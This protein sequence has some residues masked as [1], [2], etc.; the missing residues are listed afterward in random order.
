MQD[1][2]QGPGLVL[3]LIRDHDGRI[4]QSIRALITLGQD[5]STLRP[6]FDEL[7]EFLLRH[8]IVTRHIHDHNISAQDHGD[9]SFTFFIIDGLGDPAW[10]PRWIKPLGRAKIRARLARAWP[11]FEYLASI[12]GVSQDIIDESTWDQGMLRHRG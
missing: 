7:G 11:R 4:S 1:T 9:G 5:L 8:N 10:L 3:D 12:G 2:D 6:A